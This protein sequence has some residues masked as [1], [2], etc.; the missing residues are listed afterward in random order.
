M[1][2]IQLAVLTNGAV[3]ADK[4]G[5]HQDLLAT[6]PYLGPPHPTA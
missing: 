2:D 6:F 1:I 5:P 4:V 3:T